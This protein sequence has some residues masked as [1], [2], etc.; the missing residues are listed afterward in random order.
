MG[1][2]QKKTILRNDRF[3]DIVT[4]YGNSKE[5]YRNLL[6]PLIRNGKIVRNFED[7]DKIRNR[8]LSD[9]DKLPDYLKSIVG[10]IKYPVKLLPNLV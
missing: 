3:E 8:V 5:G 9:I 10:E 4:L 1:I 2:I 7:V 6:K